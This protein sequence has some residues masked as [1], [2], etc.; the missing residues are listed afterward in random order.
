LR[1]RRCRAEHQSH[2]RQEPHDR[3]S[4]NVVRR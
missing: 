3:K 1:V 4:H 2:S